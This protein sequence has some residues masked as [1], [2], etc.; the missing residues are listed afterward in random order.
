ML[1]R[2]LIV[3]HEKAVKTLIFLLIF[4]FFSFPCFAE[5][6]EQSLTELSSI[7]S[8]LSKNNSDLRN[9]IQETNGSFATVAIQALINE[10]DKLQIIIGST[11]ILLMSENIHIKSNQENPD[12]MALINK[13]I[14]MNISYIEQRISFCSS[15][16]QLETD[17]NYLSYLTKDTI[18]TL[19]KGKDS[20]N[21]IIQNQLTTSKKQE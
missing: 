18:D 19:K 15:S 4:T 17:N 6:S 13:S 7:S 8:Q 12:S 2:L 10:N 14:E 1:K 3:G 21:T 16:L 9:K 5:I 11:L 20:L